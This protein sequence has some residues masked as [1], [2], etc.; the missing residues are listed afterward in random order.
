MNYK[1]FLGI[2]SDV[3]RNNIDWEDRE[4]SGLISGETTVTVLQPTGIVGY[5]FLFNEHLILAPT[6]AIGA[7]INV[8]TDG[9]PVGEGAIFLWGLNAL[10]RF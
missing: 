10:Y 4:T 3:W 2:R 7:E 1:M 5:T 8:V 9:E 6:L